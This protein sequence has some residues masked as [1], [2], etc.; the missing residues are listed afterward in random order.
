MHQG[1]KSLDLESRPDGV[2]LVRIR[3]RQLGQAA[4][5]SLHQEMGSIWQDIAEDPDVRVLRRSGLTC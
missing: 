2:G 4:N 5:R 1:Y 3:S